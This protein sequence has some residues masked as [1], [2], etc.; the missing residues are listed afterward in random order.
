MFS[1]FYQSELAFLRATGSAYAEAHP[2]AAGFLSGRGND[3]DVERLL[4]GFAFLA[5]RIRERLEDGL[6]EVTHDLTEL[7]LPQYL[8][9]LP[10]ATV[11][12]FTPLQG[13]QA[14]ADEQA[15]N[16]NRLRIEAVRE[17]QASPVRRL[18]KGAPV[19]GDAGVAGA[20]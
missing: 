14:L 9:P 12:E 7:L 10:A 15:G 6:P 8:R 16:A 5:A 3:P 17:L 11:V 1:K 2:Q 18:V 4:E 19:A 20:G 13:A